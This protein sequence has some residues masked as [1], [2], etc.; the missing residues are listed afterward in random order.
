M[1]WSYSFYRTL[2]YYFRKVALRKT[3]FAD[4]TVSKQ[5]AVLGVSLTK[6]CLGIVR[7]YFHGHGLSLHAAPQCSM[8][9]V[10]ERSSIR[11]R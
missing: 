6:S 10:T 7:M 11:D 1:F 2:K 3:P 5:V 4:V 8:S 9:L